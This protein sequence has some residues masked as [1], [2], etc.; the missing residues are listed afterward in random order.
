MT[1]KTFAFYYFFRTAYQ[2]KYFEFLTSDVHKREAQSVDELKE[3][4]FTLYLTT[5]E[6]GG[7]KFSDLDVLKGFNVKG[8]TPIE[9][10]KLVIE[11]SKHSFK[12]CILE[13]S[14]MTVGRKSEFSEFTFL[15][16]K[17]KVISFNYGFL[18]N[19]H[20]FLFPIFNEKI[21]QMINGGLFNRL[22]VDWYENPWTLQK[23]E[24][25]E[26]VVLTM[27]H[28]EIGFTIWMICLL[29]CFAVFVIEHLILSFKNLKKLLRSLF[30]FYILRLFYQ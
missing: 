7:M 19:P 30:V 6:D 18:F 13:D 4:N 23:P 11:S 29:I 25:Q 10:D 16:L 14:I 22:I 5:N 1:Y 8:V 15:S 27:N 3:R 26:P 24:P 28:L 21:Q 9:K 12:G 2:G 20:H 17:Q